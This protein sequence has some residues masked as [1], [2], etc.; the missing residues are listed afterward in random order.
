MEININGKKCTT[1]EEIQEAIGGNYNQEIKGGVVEI[2]GTQINITV[3]KKDD[4]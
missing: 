4:K 1:P 2:K 3:T